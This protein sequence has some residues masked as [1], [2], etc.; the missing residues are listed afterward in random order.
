MS[1]TERHKMTT[2]SPDQKYLLDWYY[3]SQSVSYDSSHVY[4]SHCFCFLPCISPDIHSMSTY[5]DCTRVW[6]LLHSLCHTFLL[7]VKTYWMSCH[8]SQ[9][10]LLHQA[11]KFIYLNSIVWAHFALS[12]IKHAD[13]VSECNEA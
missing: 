6:I 9:K 3:T 7:G 8:Y 10:Y 4:H 1:N 12:L 13:Y 2:S 11:G 5:K